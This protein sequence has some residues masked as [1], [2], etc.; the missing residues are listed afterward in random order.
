M[1]P[2][3]TPLADKIRQATLRSMKARNRYADETTAELTRSMKAAQD[4][5]LRAI[6]K[7]KSLGSL[8]ENKLAGLK[9]LEKLQAEIE[10]T[11]ATLRREQTL[12]FRQGSKAAFRK[13]I[14][15][16]IEE[17]AAAQMP[18]YRDLRP[19][20]IDKL[21]TKVFTLVDTDALDFM[22]NYNLTLAGDVHREL[23]SGIKRT[24]LSGI[25]T[26]K[27]TGDI[28]RDLGEVIVDNSVHE[29]LLNGERLA[30]RFGV[31]HNYSV[32]ALEVPLRRLKRGDNEVTIYSEFDGHALEVNWPGPVLLVEFAK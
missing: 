9:G 31:M 2:P 30:N 27:G 29:L 21:G 3:K 16:G 28:V 15:Q 14:Y 19:E 32:N 4:E 12:R 8:P 7:Y 26:G 11:T 22:T 13:G 25:A 18:F 6:G 1:T 5:V 23:A 17:F 10:E 20:G 24:I